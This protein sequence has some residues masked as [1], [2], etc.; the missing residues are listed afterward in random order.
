MEM[1]ATIHVLL[2]MFAGMIPLSPLGAAIHS[3]K[4]VN[5]EDVKKGKTEIKQFAKEKRADIKKIR[6][7]KKMDGLSL[8]AHIA[9]CSGVVSL[10]LVPALSILLL[11]AGF[12]MGA[13]A[14]KDKKRYEHRRGRGLA[15]ASAAIGGA[16]ILLI[17]S[18]YVVFFLTGGF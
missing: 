6:R 5:L 9:T 3:G 4:H 16:M 2:L 12:I 15:I 8:G 13:I 7:E 10:F 14:C 18:S 17:A 11:P 1:K